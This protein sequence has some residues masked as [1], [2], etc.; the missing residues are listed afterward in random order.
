[1]DCFVIRLRHRIGIFRALSILVLIAGLIGGLMVSDRKTQQQQ[2]TSATAQTAQAA[3]VPVASP[4]PADKADAQ[5][6]AD[7]AAAVAAAQEKSADDASR[8][9]P[10]APANRSGRSGG[11]VGPIPENCQVYSGNQATGCTLMLQAGFGIDQAPCLINI[12]NKES[13]WRTTAKNPS[14]AYGI[15]Q[16]YP[17]N[18]MA[19]FG[20]DWQTNAV[21]QIK[22]GLSYIKGR[23]K[24]PCAAWSH[25]QSSGWY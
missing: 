13:G 18:K 6:K 8:K 19:Q 17:G 4:D 23:Y 1:L 5:A 11:T 24:T 16:A 15:P 25:S 22:W 7:D 12:W 3:D 21:T 9:S 14:G 20:D 10:S 2:P